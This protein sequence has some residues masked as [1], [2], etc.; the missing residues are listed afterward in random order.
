MRLRKAV[1]VL[2]VI[3]ILAIIAFSIFKIYNQES[4][5]R[6]SKTELL[7]DTVFEVA[8]FTEDEA[9]GNRLLRE[10]FNEVR[11]LEKV[12]SR[13]VSDSDVD[14]INNHAGV[15]P[16][17]VSSD[18]LEVIKKG[19]YFGELS[20]GGFDVTIAPLM[21]LWGFGTG[22]QSVPSLEEIEQT[23][24]FI[25]FRKIQVD[26][27][28]NTVYLA[29]EQMALDLGGIAKGY[30]VDRIVQF[31]Q[32]QGV[33]TA[34]VNAGGDIR[35]IGSRIDSTPWRIGIRHPRER[36]SQEI[37]AVIPVVNQAVVTSGD[38]ERYFTSDGDKYHHILD[39][40]DGFPAS[41]VISVTI[42]APDCI[43]ADGLSTAVFILG[44]QKGLEL[45][46][47]LPEVEG[48]I[49]DNQDKLYVSSGLEDI[50]EIR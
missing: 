10:S 20:D 4:I 30:I 23:L 45:L 11:A 13:F 44:P 47:R 36:D 29:D 9:E 48:V 37:I 6:Y 35:V 16:V 7:L 25:D 2:A 50:I 41:G 46:E 26:E 31:L 1:E 18:T 43:T 49:I 5:Q 33:Q 42:V 17:E 19:L 40:H 38:Y 21:D 15:E 8:V 32:S 22:E 27:R 39:P 28:R 12:L 14:I 24:P 34:F 3:I